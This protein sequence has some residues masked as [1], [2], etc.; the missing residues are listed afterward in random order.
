MTS[1]KR[2]TRSKEKMI[3]GVFTGLANYNNQ[4]PTICP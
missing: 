4:H 1:P 3:S 2:L